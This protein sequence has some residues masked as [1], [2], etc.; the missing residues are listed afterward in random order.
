MIK[1]SVQEGITTVNVYAQNTGALQ[2]V[3]QMLQTQKKKLT[4]LQ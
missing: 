4:V 2:C 3:R 1:A